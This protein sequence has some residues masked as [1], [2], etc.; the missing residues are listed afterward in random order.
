MSYSAKAVY[1]LLK[2]H[3][4]K[5]DGPNRHEILKRALKSVFDTRDAGVGTDINYV[6]ADHYLEN[7]QFTCKFGP[8][9]KPFAIAR[10]YGYDGSKVALGAVGVADVLKRGPGELSK[11]SKESREWALIGINDGITD[12]KYAMIPGTRDE[13]V[14]DCLAVLERTYKDKFG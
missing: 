4:G 1:E 2:L 5:A 11:P 8:G 9:I 7:R 3:I 6:C 10:T 12:N 13:L 14:L